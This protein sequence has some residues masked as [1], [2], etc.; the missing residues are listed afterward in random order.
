M[1][2][3]THLGLTIAKTVRQE[4]VELLPG[5]SVGHIVQG[6]NFHHSFHEAGYG[7]LKMRV[8]RTLTDLIV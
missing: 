8:E 3:L 6:G 2:G 1:T 4:E 5:L 7:A